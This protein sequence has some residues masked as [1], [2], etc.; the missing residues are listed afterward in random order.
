MA[1]RPVPEPHSADSQPDPRPAALAAQSVDL[2]RLVVRIAGK[3]TIA[4]AELYDAVSSKLYSEIR[5]MLTSPARAAGVLAA[6]F[7]EAWAL[8]RF[9]AGTQDDA[10]AWITDIAVRRTMDRQFAG[11]SHRWAEAAA[12]HAAPR[13]QLRWTVLA[14]WRD[15]QYLLSLAVLLNRP[16][17]V[18]PDGREPGQVGGTDATQAGDVAVEEPQPSGRT[19]GAQQRC[20]GAGDQGALIHLAPMMRWQCS[21][22]RL[23][24][25][26]DTS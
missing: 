4:F 16:R 1:S 11:D 21:I 14:D 15:R 12:D 23:P 25:T 6:T 19:T 22:R 8:A 26:P 18:F 9:H 2:Q 3:D 24:R 20:S 13:S 5:S 10:E 7:V 17:L